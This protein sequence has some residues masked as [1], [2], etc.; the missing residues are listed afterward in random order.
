MAQVVE[1]LDYFDIDLQGQLDENGALRVLGNAEAVQ[2]A[3]IMWIV[4]IRGEI[5]RRPGKGGYVTQWLHK[6]MSQDRAESIRDAISNGMAEDFPLTVRIRS[7]RV[8]PQYEKSSYR[9][10]LIAWIPALRQNASLDLNVNSLTNE[11]TDNN[12]E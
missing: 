3:L 11:V 4:S 9:I 12:E 1:D 6:P 10:Q 5:L 8:T 2:N 7:I